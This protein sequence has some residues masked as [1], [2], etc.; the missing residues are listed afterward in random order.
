MDLIKKQ[1]L[2]FLQY[3]EDVKRRSSRTLANYHHYLDRFLKFC[4]KSKLTDLAKIDSEFIRRY[5]NYL[6]ALDHPKMTRQTQNY[7]LIALRMLLKYGN[8]KKQGNCDH[9]KVKLG[10]LEKKKAQVVD[11]Q[12]FNDVLASPLSRHS[13]EIIKL[14]DKAILELLASS[15]LKVSEISIL[16]KRDFAGRT[17]LCRKPKMDRQLE[18]S[19]QA[20]YWLREYLQKRKDD[21]PNLFISHDK[22]DSARQK[23]K[24]DFGLS[25]RSIERIVKSYSAN[26]KQKITPQILRNTYIAQKLLS[27]ENPKDLK[28]QLGLK[29]NSAIRNNG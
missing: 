28:S 23:A 20:Q 22:A 9:R 7:H 8:I 5:N 3:W 12:T 27:G 10:K 25:P 15:G 24:E 4:E 18:L 17:L 14:R 13:S 21:R 26:Q 19:N 29:S 6:T 11:K 16:Q 2:N 1:I